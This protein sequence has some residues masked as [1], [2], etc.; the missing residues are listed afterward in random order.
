[1]KYDYLIV[2]AGLYGSV[3]AHQMRMKGKKCLIVDKRFHSGG[4]IYCENIEGINVHKYGPHIFHTNNKSCWD[5][6]CSFVEMNNF[7]YSPLANFKGELFNLPFNMNTFYQLWKSITPA[8]AQ[9]N[10]RK[11]IKHIHIVHPQNL[12]EQALLMVGSDIYNILIKGYTEKQWGRSA[13]ELPTFII[14]RLPVRYTF[15]NNYFNDRYQGIPIG[16]YNKLIEK[17][18]SGIE[19]KLNVD[20]F[21]DKSYFESIANRILFTGRIDEFYNYKF[22]KLDYRS[23]DFE[24]SVLDCENYQGNAA[25]NYTEKEIPYTRIIEHKHFELGQQNTTV[26]TKEF[27]AEFIGENEPFYPINDLFNDEIYKRYKI[28]VEQ[29]HKYI[30]G[31]R[32]GNYRYNDMDDTIV[33]AMKMANKEVII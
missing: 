33:D 19:V 7:I 17:L 14:N 11:Q 31:G 5:Y 30:F 26:I 3:F 16:G 1:M 15:N 32:L 8:Q 18:Q 23:L 29:Q 20:F 25:V 9:E 27:P 4:N 2:G 13:K 21:N 22:G 12:E 10:I 28:L 6:V 24:T